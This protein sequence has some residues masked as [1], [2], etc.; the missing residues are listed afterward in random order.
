MSAYDCLIDHLEDLRVL[1]DRPGWDGYDADPLVK[2]AV[3]AAKEFLIKLDE[4]GIRIDFQVGVDAAGPLNLFRE[5]RGKLPFVNVEFDGDDGSWMV[6]S[7]FNNFS[8][9]SAFGDLRNGVE[10][11]VE[12]LD[13]YDE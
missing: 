13:L 6:D 7:G 3:D 8:D 1:E 12:A 11:F 2:G 9:P 5:A 10:H 4:L